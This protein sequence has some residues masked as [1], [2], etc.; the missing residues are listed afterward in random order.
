MTNIKFLK[1][2]G[3]SIR[4]KNNQIILTNGKNPFSE[5]QSIESYFIPQF[6]YEKIVY[7]GDGYVSTRA[8]RS[9]LENNIHLIHVDTFG[10]L[11]CSMNTPVQSIKMTKW[12][13]GQYKTFED[14]IKVLYLQKLFIKL[15]VESEIK[16]LEYIEDCSKRKA[17]RGNFT[18][19]IRRLRHYLKMVGIAKSYND[20]HDVEVITSKLYFEEFGKMLDEKYEFKTRYNVGFDRKKKNATNVINALLNYGYSVLASDITKYVHAFGLDPYYG[21]NHKMSLGYMALV[22]DLIEPFRVLV[23]SAVLEMANARDNDD[24][25]RK[26]DYARTK[27]GYIVLDTDLINRF[28]NKFQKMLNRKRPF[29][30]SIGKK[31][32]K[33]VNM[34]HAQEST[35]IRE[36]VKQLADFCTGKQ[37]SFSI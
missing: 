18:D 6:P 17:T 10:N 4:Q 28:F 19:E 9:L 25:I 20:I 33:L 22:Y 15:K 7:S 24:R 3:F 5:S 23:D 1:G 13:M 12:R 37:S 11:I 26:R 36:H 2:Y 31:S 32:Y 14:R 34:S 35:I 27:N 30:L 29:R 21:F 16:L 8:I